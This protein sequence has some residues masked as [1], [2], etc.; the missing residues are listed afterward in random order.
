MH[1]IDLIMSPHPFFNGMS[2]HHLRLLAEGA[3]PTHFPKGTFV[4]RE[5][6]PANRFYL[7]R[8][9]S[10][11]L[12]SWINDDSRVV[13]QTLSTG[14]VL[15]WSWLFAPYYWHFDARA[16]EETDALMMFGTRLRELC[17][18]DK[19]L[20]YEIMKRVADVVIHRLQTTRLKL[21]GE[22]QDVTSLQE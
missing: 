13:L 2:E 16:L 5:G 11:S 18:S 17:E 19:V 22:P 12:E 3:S 14:D 21:V 15:G 7:I 10:V 8:Q 20:G 1:K 4:F 6:E 9:G